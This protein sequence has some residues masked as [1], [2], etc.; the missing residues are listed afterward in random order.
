[1]ERSAEKRASEKAK[2]EQKH[3]EQSN[4]EDQLG[5]RKRERQCKR[6]IDVKGTVR[7]KILNKN[8]I[9]HILIFRSGITAI[10]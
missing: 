10:Q 4:R 1:M 6:K 3:A 7:L 5:E 9:I 8:L 2:V